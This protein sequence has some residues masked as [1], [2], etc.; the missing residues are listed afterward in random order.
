L[1]GF[2]PIA[3]F[4]GAKTFSYHEPGL[5]RDVVESN[6]IKT[7][8]FV[9]MHGELVANYGDKMSFDCW[10]EK[11]IQHA[12]PA[13]FNESGFGLVLS[14]SVLEHVGRSELAQLL[15]QLRKIAAPGGWFFHAVDFGPH[16]SSGGLQR[17]Y[18]TVDRRTSEEGLLNFLRLS[19]ME[20]ALKDADFEI[21]ASVAYK[22]DRIDRRHLHKSWNS[23]SSEDLS[24]RVAIVIGKT[25]ESKKNRSLIAV[26]SGVTRQSIS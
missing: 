26:D 14:N 18:E 10:Y 22:L 7:R 23:Y 4:N 17:L 5:A 9:P 12:V 6:Q 21:V 3:I 15:Q 11:I 20:T 2:G 8:Y 25:A 16:N 13:S 24:T 19:E 1:L